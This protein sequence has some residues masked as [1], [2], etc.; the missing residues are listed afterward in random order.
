MSERTEANFWPYNSRGIYT[1]MAAITI[2][3]LIGIIIGLAGGEINSNVIMI[4][5]GS[6]LGCWVAMG[7][8]YKGPLDR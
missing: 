3:L 6:L 1:I 4:F 7:D 8:G 2:T 5:F